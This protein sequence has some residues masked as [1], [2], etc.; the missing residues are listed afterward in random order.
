M[1]SDDPTLDEEVIDDVCSSWVGVPGS[2]GGADDMANQRKKINCY[3]PC[4]NQQLKNIN[5]YQQVPFLS[6]VY[7]LEERE[8]EATKSRS[9]SE[10]A[11]LQREWCM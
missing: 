11:W 4:F 10:G 2:V 5:S 3:E 6:Q 1:L 7:G 9:C 8:G